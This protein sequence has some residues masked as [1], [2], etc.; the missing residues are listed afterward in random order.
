MRLSKKG[1]RETC[2]VGGCGVVGT[3][4]LPLKVFS[5]EISREC[6][7]RKAEGPRAR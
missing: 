2:W 7:S 6:G 1:R 4:R 3:P 5:L